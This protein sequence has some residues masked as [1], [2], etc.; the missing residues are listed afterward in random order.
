MSD[1][2]AL[3][4]SIDAVRNDPF[5][6]ELYLARGVEWYKLKCYDECSSDLMFYES[7]G[8]Q[9]P[10]FRLYLG[11][12]LSKTQSRRSTEYLRSYLSINS[13]DVDAMVFLG[14]VYY[15]G[16]KYLLSAEM[17]HMAV[18]RGYNPVI[19]REKASALASQKMFDEAAAFDPAFGKK[20]GLFRR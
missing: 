3:L 10:K 5:D 8:G 18:G 20:K 13:S 16:G 9:D 1:I 12:A 2:T 6:I 19:L 15:D 4:Q 17:F 11:M 7:S 14:H